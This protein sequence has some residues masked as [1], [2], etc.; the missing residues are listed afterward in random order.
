MADPSLHLEFQVFAP[1]A[2]IVEQ[3]MGQPVVPRD[4]VVPLPWGATLSYQGRMS[5]RPTFCPPEAVE[6]AYYFW[7]S[8]PAESDAGQVARLLWQH[9]TTRDPDLLIT[10]IVL[11]SRVQR[12]ETDPR[13]PDGERTMEA[14]IRAIQTDDAL[15]TARHRVVDTRGVQCTW[16]APTPSGEITRTIYGLVSALIRA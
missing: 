10:R 4:A 14:A 1:D 5:W 2:R 15:W 12:W 7:L 11:D 6:T 13:R 9:L 3:L 8:I 16:L